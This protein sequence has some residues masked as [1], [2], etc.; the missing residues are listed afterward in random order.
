MNGEENDKQESS[1]WQKELLEMVD[2][3]EKERLGSKKL[4][5]S[6]LRESK[7]N[8]EDMGEHP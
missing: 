3:V 2:S 1:S 8:T 5:E 6:K 7:S 4:R